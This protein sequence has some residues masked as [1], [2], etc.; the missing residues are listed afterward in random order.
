MV[1][2]SL[3]TLILVLNSISFLE[4]SI[5]VVLALYFLFTNFFSTSVS[6]SFLV[7][8]SVCLS[9]RTQPNGT[10]SSYLGGDYSHIV[11]VV[12]HSV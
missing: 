8:V 6:V 11:V 7:S 3:E 10:R 2:S 9:Q 4:M 1:A 5:V 12:T